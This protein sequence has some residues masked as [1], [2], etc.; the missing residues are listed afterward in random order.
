MHTIYLAIK[1]LT[2][3]KIAVFAICSVALCVT[4]MVL[5]TSLFNGFLDKISEFWKYEYGQVTLVPGGNIQDYS[6]AADF[7]EN[8]PEIDK[9][10]LNV[11][12]GGLLLLGR[13]NARMVVIR[14]I[15]FNR[16]LREEQFQ[17]GII[18]DISNQPEFK[19]TAEQVAFSE[20]WLEKKLRRKLTDADRPLDIVPCIFSVGLLAD[21][22]SDGSDY[23]YTRI[24][25]QLDE[26]KTPATIFS[27][28]LDNSDSDSKNIK[29]SQK[30]CWPINSVE[31]GSYHFDEKT[32]YLPFDY[33]VKEFGA[34]P[35]LL[36]TGANGVSDYDLFEAVKEAWVDYGLNKLK[37]PYEELSTTRLSISA[38]EP[39]L[40]LFISEIQK[41]L[42]IMKVILGIVCLVDG[43]L[44]FVILMMVVI[45]KRRDIGIIRAS[46]G[47]RKSISSLFLNYGLSIGIAGTI[48]GLCSGFIVVHN[49]EILENGLS[50]LL[51]FK[52]WSAKSY[53]FSAIPN[54]V[55]LPSLWWITIS[56]IITAGLGAVIP[57][58]KAA[59]TK[60]ADCLR[61]E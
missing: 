53:A 42:M 23:D 34:T 31:V 16:E 22:T 12:S 20:K 56:G 49:I 50:S 5:I 11:N 61:F 18:A 41:Q 21:D 3:R 60:P 19:L 7:L 54:Q 36:I 35:H 13:G 8:I 26:W 52:I 24:R 1:Y 14:G 17:N 59:H 46:G 25:T 51:G 47:S 27:G 58:L 32:L 29:R 28:N 10:R 48:I 44:I 30:Y 6:A 38:E 2:R 45:N 40:K 4:L 57:A 43:V 15:D 55:H 9:V 37:Q 33:V 39:W